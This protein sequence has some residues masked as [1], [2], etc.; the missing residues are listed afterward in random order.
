MRHYWGGE[1][2]CETLL[3]WNMRHCGGERVC[4]TLG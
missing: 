3:G 2:V 4:E 1:R